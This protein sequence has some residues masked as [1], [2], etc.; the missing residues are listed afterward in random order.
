[1]LNVLSTKNPASPWRGWLRTL[2]LAGFGFRLDTQGHKPPL[3]LV[4]RLIDDSVTDV[5]FDPI[6]ASND[7]EIIH[8]SFQHNPEISVMIPDFLNHSCLD[9]TGHTR[10]LPS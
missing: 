9:F 1:M 4:E 5:E 7:Q 2:S 10:Y 8:L 3:L 6:L